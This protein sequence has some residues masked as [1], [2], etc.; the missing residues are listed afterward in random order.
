MILIFVALFAYSVYNGLNETSIS[1][2]INAGDCVEVPRTFTSKLG[3]TQS[4]AWEGSNG[5]KYNLA[6]YYF[7]FNG[8]P[9]GSYE[10]G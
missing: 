6:S 1:L 10:G 4:G 8:F 5:F 3:L 7:T 9:G 2:D